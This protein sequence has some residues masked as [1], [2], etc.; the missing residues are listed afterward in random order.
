MKR[1]I[2]YFLFAVILILIAYAYIGSSA[3]TEIMHT[4]NPS[5]KTVNSSPDWKGTP[6]SESGEFKN[7]HNLSMP[8]FSKVFKW[9]SGKNPYADRKKADEFALTYL[10]CDEI[11][12]SKEDMIVW[13]GHASFLIRIEGI[14]FLTDPVF[15][16][17]IFLKR[18]SELPFDIESVKN[19]DFILLSHGHFDHCDKKSLKKIAAQ[20]PNLS[21]LCGLGM[22]KV[23]K[24][25]VP[26]ERI[27]SAGWFQ[28]YNLISTPKVTFLPSQ[29]WTRRGLFDQNKALW[30][31]FYIQSDSTSVY[32]MGDSGYEAH[33]K[34][35]QEVMGSP[36][37]ALMG[38]GAFEPEWFME[39]FHISPTDAIGAFN[40]LQ[41]GT[42]IPM[43]YGTFDLSDEPLLEP[44]RVLEKHQSEI[45]GE[46]LVPKMGEM[47]LF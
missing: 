29:H 44:I 8:A 31:G 21:I 30:G 41:A 36:N 33:F 12:E 34:E 25:I 15:Q 40:E 9:K 4:K 14:T 47:I 7:L 5:L 45:N 16:D 17:R 26:A 19:I 10:K 18:L 22:D 20:N 43:H 11:F 46:L 6:T 27:Q 35:I 37:Y 39:G 24:G 32:F 1:K 23:V 2:F 3:S 38:I 42:F 28:E 13:L